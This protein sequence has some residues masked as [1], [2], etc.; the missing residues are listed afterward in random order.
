MSRMHFLAGLVLASL[1]ITL[2]QGQQS[3]KTYTYDQ[4]GR[5]TKVEV[6]NGSQDGEQR[7][8][9]YDRADNR[10]QVDSTGANV[11]PPS[12]SCA[13][14]SVGW[15]TVQGSYGIARVFPPTPAGCG[16][17]VTLDFTITVESGQVSAS[18]LLA[19]QNSAFWIGGNTMQATD[20]AKS[21]AFGPAATDVS[22]P[23]NYV[24]KVT[25]STTTSN[26]TFDTPGPAYALVTVTP[27]P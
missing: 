2:A 15:T 1:P 11:G 17:Q 26:V 10:T 9:S 27:E 25:W 16:F 18:E 5:L 6:S 19:I 3:T 23:D 14:S 20:F 24:L 21:M 12:S 7:D 13:L 22:T 4:F 8:Y